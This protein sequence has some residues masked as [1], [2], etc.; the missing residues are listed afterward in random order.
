[1]YETRIITTPDEAVSILRQ[2]GLVAVPTETVY[3][4]AGRADDAAVVARIFKAKGRPSD[5]PLIVHVSSLDQ[6][7][8]C[9]ARIPDYALTL[10]DVFW[11]GPLTLV[12]PA[13]ESVPRVVTAGLDTVGIRMPDHAVTRSIIGKLGHPLAAP[14]ANRSGRPSP[15]TW[16][17]VR[18]DLEGRIEAILRSEPTSVGLESTVVDCTGDHPVILRPGGVSLST[19]V[20][21]HPGARMAVATDADERSPGRRH[22][23]Y[24]PEAEVRWVG[25]FTESDGEAEA[26]TE[27]SG[28][29]A[30]IGL[31]HPPSAMSFSRTLVVPDAEAYA[32]ALF[33]FFRMCESEGIR[34]ICCERIP[35]E[36]LGLAL[37]DRI[38]R[39][40]GAWEPGDDV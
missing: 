3:G 38:D 12:L 15:T 31:N 19:L 14:S 35:T 23:H 40:A 9:A 32:Q 18:D 8:V 34:V 21:V 22:R 30:Y 1:M 33:H 7:N 2:G 6:V 36:G 5:N 11:P 37:T 17:A 20:A 26:P 39:A 13:R 27:M 28:G 29:S 24:R 10:M 4:L 16:E 25:P